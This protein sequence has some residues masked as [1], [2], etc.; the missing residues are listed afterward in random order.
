M[1]E[2]AEVEVKSAWTSK[3][4]WTQAATVAFSVATLFGID[5]PAETKA[6]AITVITAAGGVVTWALRTW[7][8]KAVT[9]S[10]VG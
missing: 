10:S 9:P 4:N 6:Q 3:I 5:V 8:T 1:T 7:F 2:V